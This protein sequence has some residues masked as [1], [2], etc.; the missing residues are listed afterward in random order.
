M[1]VLSFRNCNDNPTRDYLDEYYMLLVEMKDFNALIDSKLYFD[2]LVKHKQEAYE[3][4][5]ET[6]RNNDY[7]TGNVLDY[8]N[9]QKYC[10]FIVID[11]SRQ[12]NASIPQGI[13]FTGKCKD[14]DCTT[15]FS[16]A[17]KQ[18]KTFLNFSL[19][20]LIVTE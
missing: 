20:S 9:H 12:T 11:V 18:K 4:L 16:I 1:F 14:D 3:K 6:S 13:N 5:V 19:D 15:M 7:K 17:E 2:Q 8:L 10:K